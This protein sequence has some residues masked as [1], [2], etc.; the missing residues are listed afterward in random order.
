MSQNIDI[1]DLIY[2]IN[3]DIYRALFLQRREEI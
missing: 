1:M 3:R 2:I